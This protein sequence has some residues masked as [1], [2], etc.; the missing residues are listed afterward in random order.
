MGVFSSTQ[1]ALAALQAS[2]RRTVMWLRSMMLVG[3]KLEEM[4]LSTTLCEE[5]YI[6]ISLYVSFPQQPN[7]MGGDLE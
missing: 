4:N 7:C 2:A 5:I 6:C 1:E 3:M